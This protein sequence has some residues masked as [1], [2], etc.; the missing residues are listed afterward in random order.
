MLVVTHTSA[1][2]GAPL[3]VWAAPLDD[4]R[5]ARSVYVVPSAAAEG[6]AV[7]DERVLDVSWADF[8]RSLDRRHP[9]VAVWTC[10]EVAHDAD[11]GGL[12]RAQ[13]STW[14]HGRWATRVNLTAGSLAETRYV[15]A[16]DRAARLVAGAA[17]P[18]TTLM[19][20]RRVSTRLC[21]FT[22]D[23]RL[24]IVVGP[25]EPAAKVELAL[26]HGLAYVANRDLILVLPEGAESATL[27]RAPWLDLPLRVW[28]YSPMDELALQ[29]I[30][31]R[32]E[33][34]G[35]YTDEIVTDAHDL[36]ADGAK[37]VEPIT[38]WADANPL[39]VP[40]HRRSYLAWH[41]RG[42]LVL[43]VV[44][45]GPALAVSAG[46]HYTKPTDSK[47]APLT[48]TPLTGPLS[49]EQ[50]SA[51][52]S[53]VDAAIAA[54]ADG[55]DSD[56]AE[57]ELQALL[58]A[59]QE[60]LGLTRVLREVPAFRPR[61][62]RSFIDLLGV[63]GRGRLHVVET[64]IGNDD[65]LVLQ[66]L[67]YWIWAHAHR[68][69]LAKQLGLKTDPEVVIDYVTADP[70]TPYVT[71]P[72]TASQAEM[73]DGSIS[74]Q[75]HHVSN[76]RSDNP[77][78]EH[79]PQRTAPEPTNPSRHSPARHAIVLTNQLIERTVSPLQR[80][81]FFAEAEDAIAPAARW[82]YDDLAARDLLHRYV[83][84]VRS[85]QAFALNLFGPLGRS[86]ARSLL[87]TLGPD[88]IEG[89]RPV[90]EYTGNDDPLAERSPGHPH[91]TQVDVL[92]RG[93]TADG[94][95][96][97]A[98]IEVKLSEN[99]FGHCSA[100]LSPGNDT[101]STCAVSQPF[102]GNPAACFQL[103]N[104]DG[105]GH[106]RYAE[107]LS[108]VTW[109]QPADGGCP[110]R[111]GGNQPMRNI[112]LAVAEIEAGD[113]DTVTYALCAPEHNATIWRRWR[114][115][116]ALYQHVPNVRLA[117]L[118]ATTVFARH[119]VPGATALAERYGLNTDAIRTQAVDLLR[120]R[121]QHAIAVL[122]R[123]CDDGSILQQI[124]AAPPGTIERAELH[125]IAVLSDA[126]ATAAEQAR[127]A[128]EVASPAWDH[129]EQ[130]QTRP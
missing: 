56:N 35:G 17:G 80:R 24:A 77:T 97:I 81:V 36:G 73:L 66:G 105:G 86:G 63:D 53:T 107:R 40:A 82:A 91:M 6:Q 114:E 31:A 125:D 57:H 50:V 39:L 68:H 10:T 11:L 46:V 110:F 25:Q 19:P 5:A 113:A 117:D 129:L 4:E 61:M 128:D 33:V 120:Q 119:T 1:R 67:D 28:T 98:F 45:A 43:R 96:H 112:A 13:A 79:L 32:V 99:D 122:R 83:H 84:H 106:R 9:Y 3:G 30:P 15:F 121:V 89:D 87:R 54:R 85:S 26:A 21:M 55:S 130:G 18:T 69:D 72:Y 92:L 51:V 95:C 70:D 60:L 16:A 94:A 104:H 2:T 116:K 78:I 109:N 127:H 102:G 34:L 88:V 65:M 103:R 118:P 52:I 101:R 48:L 14:A 76:W 75:F 49:P 71:G 23:E 124:A 59:R 115:A 47:P 126:V 22:D 7:M 100:Y 37:W 64:K 90:F 74:W 108:D 111:L 20:T 12:I 38:A 29:V 93:H 44:R 123:V 27:A 58:T 8:F 41:T 42:R 62:T